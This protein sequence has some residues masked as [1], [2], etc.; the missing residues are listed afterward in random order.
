MQYEIYDTNCDLSQVV[1]L[2]LLY[3]ELAEWKS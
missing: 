2:W 3:S 1:S